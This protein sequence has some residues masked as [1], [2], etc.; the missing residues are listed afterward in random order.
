MAPYTTGKHAQG[1]LLQR[2]DWKVPTVVLVDQSVRMQANYQVVA[3]RSRCF[4]DRDVA[5]VEQVKSP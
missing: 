2:H 3:L 1:S 5:S 4:Q